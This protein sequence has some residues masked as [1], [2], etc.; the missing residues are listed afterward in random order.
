MV[1][2]LRIIQGGILRVTQGRR[3]TCN[4]WWPFIS[5][6]AWQFYVLYSVEVFRIT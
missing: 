4:T 3:F 6:R 2:I 1:E 5:N